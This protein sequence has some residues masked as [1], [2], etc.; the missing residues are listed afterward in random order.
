VTKNIVLTEALA[1]SEEFSLTSLEYKE[2]LIREESVVRSISAVYDESDLISETKFMP[3]TQT[4]AVS[5]EFSLTN[6]SLLSEIWA[7]TEGR[8]VD[9]SSLNLL[10]GT[11]KKET[12]R[13]A[14]SYGFGRTENIGL[15]D[16]CGPYF[17]GSNELWK[18]K[19]VGGSEE[20]LR[21]MRFSFSEELFSGDWGEDSARKRAEWME[22]PWL[23]YVMAVCLVWA[24]GITAYVRLFYF[25]HKSF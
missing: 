17:S 21:T 14:D 10:E 22:E 6:G 4:L 1:V 23:G 11:V 18:S 8:N 7:E 13:L 15:T 2:S 16:I 3:A 20:I 5:E 24:C 25:E 9:V 12:S 19:E